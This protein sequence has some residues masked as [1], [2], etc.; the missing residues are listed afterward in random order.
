MDGADNVAFADAVGPTYPSGT[1]LVAIMYASSSFGNPMV[2]FLA[3]R[4]PVGFVVAGMCT[5]AALATWMLW[6]LGTNSAL[7]VLFSVVWG[8]L[9]L[10]LAATWSQMIS[11]VASEQQ[12][13]SM[14]GANAS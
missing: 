10:P 12:P 2:G 7:L 5:A 13:Q 3:D 6:G 8:M 9:A 4:F 1:G 14:S 11:Y